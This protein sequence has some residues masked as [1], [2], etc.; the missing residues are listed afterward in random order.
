MRR[1]SIWISPCT[2]SWCGWRTSAQRRR[3]SATSRGTTCSPTSRCCD[4]SH[5]R[6]PGDPLSTMSLRGHVAALAQFFGNTGSWGWPGVP[7]HAIVGPG[8]IPRLPMRIPRFI[9]DAEL[10]RLMAAIASLPCPYQRT[11]LLI[12]RWSGCAQGRDS[13]PCGRLLR[14]VSGRDATPSDSR[15]KKLPRTD[16]SAT[17]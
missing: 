16:R 11:A 13:A 9:P 10:Q 8:D 6:A 15:R 5:R 4:G 12:A 2:D 17:R 3:T 7:S 14:S 1:P